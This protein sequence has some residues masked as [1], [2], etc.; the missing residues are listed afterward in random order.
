MATKAERFKLAADR[1]AQGKKA[2]RKPQLPQSV[3]KYYEASPGYA[4]YWFNRYHQ[5]RIWN[6]YLAHGDFAE[7]GWNWKIKA[8]PVGANHQVEI[9]LTEKN[10]SIVM[11]VTGTVSWCASKRTS[12]PPSSAGTRPSMRATM[13]SRLGSIVC[14]S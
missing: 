6:A 2:K 10:G 12:G 5:Q 11:P 7:L 9:S 4:N 3:R 13:L 8:K 14:R 1:A